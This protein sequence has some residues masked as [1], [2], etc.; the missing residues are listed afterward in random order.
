VTQKS[1]ETDPPAANQADDEPFPSVADESAQAGD[2]DAGHGDDDSQK[3]ST[4]AVVE[5]VR[6]AANESETGT[7][8]AS[9][10]GGIPTP[11]N[12]KGVAVPAV[13]AAAGTS[14]EADPVESV[15]ITSIAPPGKPDG[16]VDT[17][18]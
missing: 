1:N 10:T 11:G 3:T 18:S 17:R 15:R 9:A 7:M 2:T 16:E 8:P 13:Q 4:G 14:E 12:S 5:D 6:S